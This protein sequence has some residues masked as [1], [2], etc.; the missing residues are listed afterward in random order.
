MVIFW[1]EQHYF[2]LMHDIIAR[3]GMFWNT[4]RFSHS[5]GDTAAA[6]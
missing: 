5:N 4:G 1:R 6:A 2:E 3:L